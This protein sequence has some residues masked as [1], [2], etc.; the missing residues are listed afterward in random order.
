MS[1]LNIAVVASNGLFILHDSP[2]GF[3]LLECCNRKVS[4][5]GTFGRKFTS[6]NV[7]LVPT[8]PSF[9][10]IVV[11][12]SSAYSGCCP[13][14]SLPSSSYF[15]LDDIVNLWLLKVRYS[16]IIKKVNCESILFCCV[17]GKERKFQRHFEPII[18]KNSAAISVTLHPVVFTITSPR[19]V[20][21]VS[22]IL[23]PFRGT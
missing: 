14:K 13:T 19:F 17:I 10:T 22:N 8:N 11:I 4:Q 9:S 3:H 18:E 7:Y 20:T 15:L 1:N 5:K 16:C 21:R 12:P 23:L 2:L 6:M